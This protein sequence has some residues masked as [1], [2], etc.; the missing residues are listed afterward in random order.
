LT[1]AVELQ[2]NDAETHQALA[3]C[4]DR[5]QDKEGA[6][7]QLLRWRELARREIKLYDD[8]G[9]RYQALN[10]PEEAERAYT[11][12]VEV[13]PSESESHALLAEIR[14]Q[15]NRWPEA[16]VQWEQVARIRALEPAG[17]EKLAAAQ[18]HQRQWEA[19]EITLRKLETTAWPSRFSNVT[20]QV[21]N[22]RRQ[23]EDAKRQAEPKR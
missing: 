1:L 13:L 6:I 2:P 7:R 5:Q 23:M 14:Q 22:L 18:I 8:L 20:S 12:I 9:K 19:A 4:Y 15:Q 17:L 21:Y 3:A 11:S 10:K 16:I